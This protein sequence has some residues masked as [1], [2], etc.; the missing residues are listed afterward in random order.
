[1]V[2]IRNPFWP[3]PFAGS[4]ERVSVSFTD[5]TNSAATLAAAG[6]VDFAR[7]SATAIEQ[8]RAIAP[9]R[10][11]AEQGTTLIVLGFSFER[12]NGRATRSSSGARHSAR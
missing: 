12:A 10:L 7:L 5:D 8:A 9:D 4:I 1:M 2:L 3:D 11:Y 6:R